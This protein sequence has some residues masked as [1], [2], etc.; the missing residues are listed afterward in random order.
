MRSFLVFL[1]FLFTAPLAWAQKD[2][3]TSEFMLPHC[4]KIEA[5]SDTFY[6]GFCSGAAWAI[7]VLGPY[8]Q[9]N[10]RFCPPDTVSAKEYVKV[11]ISYLEAHPDQQHETLATSAIKA[12]NSEWPCSR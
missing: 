10:V 6:L 7:G 11:L 8:F 12:F 3:D 2:P 1:L 4:K 9:T 5:P